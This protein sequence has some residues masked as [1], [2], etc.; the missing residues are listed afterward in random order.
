MVKIFTVD[1]P[2]PL[3]LTEPPGA[4][5][6]RQAQKW[7][8]A[9][10]VDQVLQGYSALW[11]FNA[12]TSSQIFAMTRRVGLIVAHRPGVMHPTVAARMFATLDLLAGPGRLALNVV[13]GSSDKDLAREGDYSAKADRYDRA[14]EYVEFMKQCWTSPAAFDMDGRFYKAE[15]VRQLVR[16]LTGHIP[17]Y[18]GGDSP[19]AVDFGAQHADIYMLWGE[20]LA[21]TAERIRV[22]S[23][24]AKS[25]YDRRPE[26]SLSLRLFVGETED[27]AWA[28]ARA[29][30]TAILQAQGTNKFS[31][32]SSTDTSIGRQ[33]QLAAAEQELHDTCFWTA[34]VKLLGGFANS[35]ALVGTREQVMASLKAYRALG[36]DAF[37]ITGGAHGLWEPELEDFLVDARQELDRVA[38]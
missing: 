21:G 6:A 36:I 23:E 37:L 9:T 2:I 15:G 5:M 30:E 27:E 19:D 1:T 32:S 14:R 16:P 25:K 38:A 22:V 4:A 8:A 18:M 35:A 24:V 10:A 31:R 17:I 7:E 11:P 3:A 29:V 12:V 34:L 33:R 28:K 26:F 13:S 20:P